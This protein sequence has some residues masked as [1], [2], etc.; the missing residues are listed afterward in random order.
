MSDALGLNAL[1]LTVFYE[2]MAN[3]EAANAYHERH[4]TKSA[5]ILTI[6]NDERAALVTDY[7][8]ERIAGKVVVE[9]GAG[10]GLLACHMAMEAKKVYAIELE[11]NWA[12]C[13]VATLYEKKPA[14]LCYIFG[15]AEEAPY[16]AA[17]VALFCTLSGRKAMYDAA[18]RFS[19]NVIDVYAELGSH[20]ETWKRL[21]SLMD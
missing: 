4:D 10:I 3:N 14:N 20:T 16:I 8:R 17:D 6:W 18:Y 21:E 5:C 12:S 13:F 15:K 2:C 11:P 7:L 19:S 1:N 9:V